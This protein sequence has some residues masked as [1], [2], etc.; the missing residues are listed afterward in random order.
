MRILKIISQTL[1]RKHKSLY[2]PTLKYKLN[3][4]NRLKN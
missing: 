2:D 3:D 1:I 4:Q